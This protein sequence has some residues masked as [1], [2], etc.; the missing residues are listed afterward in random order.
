MTEHTDKLAKIVGRLLCLLGFHDFKV[1]NTTLGFGPAGGTS[2]VQCRR[3]GQ[4]T[5]RSN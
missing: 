3:C 1:I 4:V 5:M 2:K